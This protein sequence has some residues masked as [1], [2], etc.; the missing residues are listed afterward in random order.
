MQSTATKLNNLLKNLEE[1]DYNKAI[2][3]IEFL[4]DRRKK[5]ISD[6]KFAKD[7]TD[8]EDIVTSLTGSIPD[9]GKSLAEYRNERL[10]KYENPY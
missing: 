10:K 6:R 1:E 5:Q 2:S 4:A 3:Y 9:T 8:V 7:I